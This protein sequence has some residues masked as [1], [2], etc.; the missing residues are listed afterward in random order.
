M[1]TATP[2][3]DPALPWSGGVA[4]TTAILAALAAIASMFAQ[5]N[6]T[7]AMIDQVE[8]SDQ[9]SYYQAKGIKLAVIENKMEMLPALNV[10]PSDDDKARAK[11]YADEQS[12]ISE[13]AKAKQVS[14]Q[15]HRR[16]AGFHAQAASAAQIGIALAAIALLTKRQAFWFVSL[17][18]AA[19]SIAVLAYG[20]FSTGPAAAL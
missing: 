9:W 16:R 17:G 15:D 14:A 7:E 11:R 2:K 13:A 4:I 12:K 5:R 3:T 10:Q 18:F 1:S 19:V 8:T 20:F 6:T